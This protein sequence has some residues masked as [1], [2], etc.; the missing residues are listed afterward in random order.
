MRPPEHASDGIVQV[1]TGIAKRVH[2][3]HRR[4]RRRSQLGCLRVVEI[5][6]DVSC[7][8]LGDVLGV[9][10]SQAVMRCDDDPLEDVQIRHG[11]D[12]LKRAD[13]GPELLRTGVPRLTA[14]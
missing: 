12:V 4:T 10:E 11:E 1:V 13:L 5:A 6:P 8:D 9:D 2:A 14:S 3:V 7:G